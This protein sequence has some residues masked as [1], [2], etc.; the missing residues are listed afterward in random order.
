MIG[1]DFDL[2]KEG[3]E[4]SELEVLF[5]VLRWKLICSI[6]K[7]KVCKT[8]KGLHLKVFADVEPEKTI[9]LRIW[10]G[11][12]SNRLE[13]D[14]FRLRKANKKLFFDTLFQY[15]K[16]LKTGKESIEKC[17]DFEAFFKSFLSKL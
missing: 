16:E 12:D 14:I 7:C 10:L 2:E 3:K 1:V 5:Y 15:K 4:V 11:D 9:P 13:L 8:R 17:L 6:Y